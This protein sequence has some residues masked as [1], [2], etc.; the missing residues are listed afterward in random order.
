M[1]APDHRSCI[2]FLSRM[3]DN[4]LS[5]SIQICGGSRARFLHPDIAVAEKQ[6]YWVSILLPAFGS[7]KKN[8]LLSL[9]FGGWFNDDRY[10]RHIPAYALPTPFMSKT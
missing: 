7:Q 9:A 3:S 4:A 2:L 8:C 5:T 6:L 10:G 1:S